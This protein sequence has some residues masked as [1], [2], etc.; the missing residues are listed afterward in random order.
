MH[1]ITHSPTWCSCVAEDVILQ[2]V[3][4]LY[5]LISS[6]R[7]S[8]SNPNL[9]TDFTPVWIFHGSNKTDATLN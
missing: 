7:K 6:D 3:F 1:F 2:I 5:G 9:P 4:K 8:S